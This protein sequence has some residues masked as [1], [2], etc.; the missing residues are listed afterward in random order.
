MT[1]ATE[2]SEEPYYFTFQTGPEW[3]KDSGGAWHS[4]G[5]KLDLSPYI[6]GQPQPPGDQPRY[7]ELFLDLLTAGINDKGHIYIAHNGPV[8]Q[9]SAFSTTRGLAEVTP[10]AGGGFV[11]MTGAV[12]D[13]AKPETLKA[14]IETGRKWRG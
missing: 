3:Y 12:I 8:A 2:S 10:I 9:P 6:T 4:T 1:G 14:M 5:V 7:V 13:D 11:L